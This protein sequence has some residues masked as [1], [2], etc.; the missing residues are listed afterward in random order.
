M[1][2]KGEIEAEIS[3]ALVRFEIDYIGRGPKESRSYIIEDMILARLQGVLTPAEQQLA[4]NS[5]GIELV[6][7]MRQTLIEGAKTHLSQVIGDITS[8]KVRE[9][10]TDMSTICGERVFV[11]ILDRNLEKELPRKR[12]S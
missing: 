1:K 8:A 12:N 9:I 3:E 6:R 10:H 11:F 5:D 4:K 7:K 2:T